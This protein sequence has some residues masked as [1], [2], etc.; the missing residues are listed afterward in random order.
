[1]FRITNN[2]GT[3]FIC[4][5]YCPIKIRNKKSGIDIQFKTYKNVFKLKAG[6]PEN[7]WI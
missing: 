5:H 4:Y 3:L 7:N 1:M 2:H 6:Y